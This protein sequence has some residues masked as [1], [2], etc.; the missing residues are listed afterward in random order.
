MA[1]Q[2]F[3]R[4]FTAF[5]G[6]FLFALLST[7]AM[8]LAQGVSGTWH[9]DAGY[10]MTFSDSGGTF[11]GSGAGGGYTWVV[12]NGVVA[13]NSISWH[14]SYNELS[15]T[16]E[17]TGTVSGDSMSGT[18]TTSYGQNLTWAATRISGGP[19]ATPTATPTAG[20]KRET[21]L[22]LFCNRQ[23][24]NL[25][26]ASCT[27]TLADAG[28]PPRTVPTGVV[29][30]SAAGGFVPASAQCAPV[31]TQYSPGIGSCKAEFAVPFG[32]PTGAAFP[33]EAF[34]PGDSNFEESASVHSLIQAGCVG[35]PDTP[36]SGGVSATFADIP[37]IIRNILAV[38]LQCGS[39]KAPVLSMS[40]YAVGSS[41]SCDM[42]SSVGLQFGE[43]LSELNLDQELAGA[44]GNA[45]GK[46]NLGNSSALEALRDMMKDV[47]KGVAPLGSL[48]N[49]NELDQIFRL[50]LKRQ[51]KGKRLAILPRSSSRTRHA[52]LP[53]S[54]AAKKLYTETVGTISV[55]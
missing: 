1:T 17:R 21:A 42:D 48:D 52:V 50:Y 13:G 5:I 3:H 33:I 14:E 22:Q 46:Q 31:Q 26:I 12:T 45:L 51:N 39:T 16:V 29:T 8:V 41:D 11:T 40:P 28:P 20:S 32:F 6:A 27:V 38:S 9:F 15:Y 54:A 23:G 25:E 7:P 30:F 10:D 36:C 34:Y 19:S 35:T 4:R 37:A 44:I 49:P 47:G 53:P 18:A 24:V 2:F 55:S 43:I